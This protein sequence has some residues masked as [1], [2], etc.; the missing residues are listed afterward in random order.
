[1]NQ[2]NLIVMVGLPRSGKSTWARE[3]G[4]PI[5][6]P[7]AIRLAIH[8]QRFLTEAEPWVWVVAKTMVKALFLAGHDKVIVDGCHTSKKR[9][10]FWEDK[11]WNI[12]LKVID[13]SLEECLARAASEQDDVIVPI[14]KK[15]HAEWDLNV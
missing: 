10:D 14:I 9:R 1:M 13:T 12:E 4:Y 8:G 5:V 6:N 2:K 11:G 7:D 3:Q 15:M